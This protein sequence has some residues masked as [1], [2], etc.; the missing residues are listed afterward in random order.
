MYV[1]NI[2]VEK[3]VILMDVLLLFLLNT[4]PISASLQTGSERC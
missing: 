4:F 3:M 2:Y 1:N